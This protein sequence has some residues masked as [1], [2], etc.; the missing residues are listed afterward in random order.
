MPKSKRTI[1]AVRSD[2]HGNHRLGLLNPDTNLQYE[3]VDGKITPWQPKPLASQEVLWG[4]AEEDRLAVA[5]LAKGDEIVLFDLGDLGHG[6]GNG[7]SNNKELISTRVA[8]EIEIAAMLYEPWLRMKNITT[9]RLF[10][11]TAFHEGG[12]GS[13]AMAVASVL[14]GRFPRVNTQAQYHALDTIHG[15]TFDLAHHGPPPGLRAW[16]RGNVL[17]L[18]TRSLMMDEILAGRRPPDVVLR[19]H[20]HQWATRVV[21]VSTPAADFETRAAIVPSYCLVDDYARK[22]GRSPSSVTIGM[23]AYEIVD[24]RLVAQ[25]AFR[26]TIDFRTQEVLGSHG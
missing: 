6:A 13:L 3:G 8:D 14:S 24:G 4:F 18:Y 12:Q 17:E 21:V 23:V 10:K 9:L 2:L 7:Y 25:H 26:R 5:E 22:I 1:V 20:Y 15:V 16:L 11:G 19:G